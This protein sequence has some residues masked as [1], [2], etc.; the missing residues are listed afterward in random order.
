MVIRRS[1]ICSQQGQWT[2]IGLLVSL[3]IIMILAAM[4]IPQV[5]KRHSEP[6]EARTPMERGYGTACAS[7]EGQMN[8]AVT[9]YKMDHDD[10][11]PSNIEELKKYGVTDDMIHSEGC[12]FIIDQSTGRV[13]DIGQGKGGPV[14]KPLPR[15]GV[16]QGFHPDN[17]NPPKINNYQNAP[18]SGYSGY[19]NP[20][21]QNNSGYNG[22]PQP[23]TPPSAA[24]SEDDT[25]YPSQPA[26]PGGGHTGP[27]GIRIPNIPGSGM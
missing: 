24:P 18:N 13:T 14:E 1:R 10:H 20:Q 27:G 23:N 25:G 22:Y 17:P 11:A 4:Y 7:Y 12:Y 15:P 9:M 26:Q 3:G 19:N 5:A 8:Q 21:P 16:S 6:G 2:L